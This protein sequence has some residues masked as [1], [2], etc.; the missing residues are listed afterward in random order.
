MIACAVY[1]H[2]CG[3]MCH[4]NNTLVSMAVGQ[5]PVSIGLARHELGGGV[6]LETT[7]GV[8]IG[9]AVEQE[10]A[11]NDLLSIHGN[12][13]RLVGQVWELMTETVYVMCP[14]GLGCSG[15]FSMSFAHKEE[16]KNGLCS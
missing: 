9:C 13:L 7:V 10:V 4:I 14:S 3:C 1:L 12:V 11:W 8:L 16:N 5:M 6:N 2:L 15:L